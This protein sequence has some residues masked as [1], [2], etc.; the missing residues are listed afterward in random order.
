M[1]LL[2]RYCGRE[3]NYLRAR[4]LCWA[5]YHGEGRKVVPPNSKYASRGL[6]HERCRPATEPTDAEPG[7]EAKVETMAKRLERGEEIFHPRDAAIR[8]E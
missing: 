4:G 2:C 3:F 5:C 8:L 1:M 7:T 6:G